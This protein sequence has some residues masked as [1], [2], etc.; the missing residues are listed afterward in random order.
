[1]CSEPKNNIYRTLNEI[2]V[3]SIVYATI[4]E[5]PTSKLRIGQST[6]VG[7][8]SEA[9]QEY[10]IDNLSWKKL[11]NRYTCWAVKKDVHRCSYKYGSVK[12]P[13]Q[14]MLPI[15]ERLSGQL[16]VSQ[17]LGEEYYN[18]VNINLY[19]DGADRCGWHADDEGLFE[20]P[21]GFS[22]AAV[23][24]GATR[25]FEYALFDGSQRGRIHR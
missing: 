14:T 25:T 12:A 7:D 23:S 19:V 20:N 3:S 11:S 1:M 8:L 24:L 5:T 16:G 10:L 4:L 13:T 21:D 9:L 17:G 15:L 6:L 18:S 2:D 22:I